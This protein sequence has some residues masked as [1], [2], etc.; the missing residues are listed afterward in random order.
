MRTLALGAAVPV[1]AIAVGVALGAIVILLT[2]ADPVTAFA[3]LVNGAL[4]T[5]SNIAATILRSVP[6]IVAG[7]GIGVALRAGALNL[8]GE[9]QMVMGS[10]ASAAIATPLGGIPGPFGIAIALAV[11]CLAGAA[12]A[13][14]PAVLEVRLEVPML[15][16]TLLMNYIGALFAAWVATYPLRD[17][18]G[19]AAVAQTAIIPQQLWLPIVLTGTRLHAGIIALVV[20]PLLVVWLMRRT[21]LG[22][23][24]RM[25]GA[26][27]LFAE[28]GGINAGRRVIVATLLS[29]AVCGLG[30][31]L[32]VLGLNHR[33]IDTFVTSS[34]FAWSGF[35][36]AILTLASPIATVLAGLFLGGLQVGAAGMTRATNVPLQVVDVVQAAIILVVAVRP[37]IRGALRRAFRVD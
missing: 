30:G 5:Q 27:R 34:G 24:L 15:I 31:G 9:G 3:A 12:W 17:L 21:V 22:Y 8:G 33:Y 36:A 13:F 20:L 26:N 2:G 25:T 23:E 37:A 19:G 16:T 28:Y 29:G 6:I 35:I 14:L 10:L 18:T 1:L 7:I 32:I 4:G 11:G